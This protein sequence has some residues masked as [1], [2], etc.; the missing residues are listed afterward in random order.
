MS[1]ICL[2]FMIY[3]QVHMIQHA[4]KGAAHT[5]HN[6]LRDLLLL[7]YYIVYTLLSPLRL[8][9]KQIL[10]MTFRSLT[11]EGRREQVGEWVNGRVC[12]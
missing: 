10:L 7:P 3:G 4:V 1:N 5:L 2:I 6:G 9:L 12:T 11:I 8:L